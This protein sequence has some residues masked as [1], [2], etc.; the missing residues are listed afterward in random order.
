[1]RCVGGKV[2]VMATYCIGDVQGCFA[3]LIKLLEVIN[4]DNTKDRLWFVGDLVNRGSNSLAVLR[5]VRQ[6][7]N[8]VV[9]LGNHDLHLLMVYHQLRKSDSVDLTKVITAPD[10]EDLIAWLRTRPLIHHDPELN[11]VL[12]HAGIYPFWDLNQAK[13][14][15]AEVTQ[16]LHG[17][18]YL[19]FLRVL[20]GDQPHKWRSDLVG[21]DRWRFIVNS[22]TRMRFCNL[23]GELDFSAKTI[24]GSEPA[25]FLPWFE[26]NNAGLKGLKLLFGHWAAL[27]GKVTAPNIFALDTGCVWG[28]SLTAICLENNKIFS[29]KCKTKL[30]VCEL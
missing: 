4:Y 18:N 22:F 12:S 1:M 6:L 29:Y 27:G 11:F 15:A 28:G 20:Y 5:F 26:I 25:G 14:Y 3:E 7:K 8:A 13:A 19:D 17:D 2:E 30:K 10:A 21:F 23:D 16:V 9:V 24:I